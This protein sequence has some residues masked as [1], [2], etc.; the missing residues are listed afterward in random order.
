M[1]LTGCLGAF[2]P[3]QAGSTN[4]P[5]TVQWLSFGAVLRMLLWS[6]LSMICRSFCGFCLLL[7]A[8]TGDSI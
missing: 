8:A 1:S 2:W 5:R 3:D 4:L 7:L 6:F